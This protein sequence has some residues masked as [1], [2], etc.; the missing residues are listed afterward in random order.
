[1]PGETIKTGQKYLMN[2]YIRMPLTLLRGEGA[3]VWDDE[4]KEYLDFISGLA[5]NALGH[6]HPRVTEAVN[7]QAQEL[8]HCSNLYWI[9]EQVELAQILVNN[10]IMDR[11][12]FC[13]S[14]G[15]ANEA[16][17][18]LVRKHMH[19]RG[20]TGEVEIIS[21]YNSFHG[22]S[23]ATLAATGQEK[24]HKGFEP[25]PSGFKY[26]PLNDIKAL[27][28]AL[29]PQ[30]R[31]LMVEPIQGEGGVYPAKPEYLKFMRELC[32]EHEMLLIFDE[33]QCGMGR[34][35]FL[36]AYQYFGVEP[37]IITMAK[38]LANGVPIGVL[39]AKEGIARSFVPGDHGSTF[40]GNP[41][42]CAA[43]K[44]VL[45]TILE[46]GILENVQ[47]ISVYFQEKMAQLAK[48]HFKIQE[49]RGVGL[50]L[51]AELEDSGTFVAQRCREKGLLINCVKEKILRFLPPLNITEK[52]V[53]QAVEILD[54]VLAEVES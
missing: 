52:E 49:I 2:T 48:K 7:R 35:G 22:R 50:M 21:C 13:N 14:G 38:G 20:T 8:I 24:F 34:T 31:A 33:V 30:T 18:K 1:M 4:G 26:V 29:S 6:A 3:R 41:L 51:A 43:G 45:E 16:A 15:E 19:Q 5:V 39:L 12:F 28:K 53:D 54:S 46:G 23:L 42:A 40:G 25:L 37:D 27:E 36:F 47:R 11:V 32:D 17:I 44:A 9:K 10:S